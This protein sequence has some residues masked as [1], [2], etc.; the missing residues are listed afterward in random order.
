VRRIDT[1]IPSVLIENAP[2][3]GEDPPR[4]S[5]LAVRRALQLGERTPIV[6]YTGTFEAYQDSTAVRFWSAH[7]HGLHRREQ[8]V[9]SLIGLETCRCTG[10]SA[11]AHQ[12]A[13]RAGRKADP[14]VGVSPEP[15]AFSIS[16][17]GI[18]VSIRRTTSSS[19]GTDHDHHARTPDDKTLEPAE[20]GR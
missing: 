2:G 12:A 5:G 13:A 1:A 3:S 8:Q 9:E 16:T 14:A 10:R 15:G 20:H 11:S 7:D 18:A 17:D 6:L 19:C 4:G